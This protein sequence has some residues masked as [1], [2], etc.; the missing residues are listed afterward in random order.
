MKKLSI[1]ILILLAC[2]IFTGCVNSRQKA[3][4]HYG[5][6]QIL[7]AQGKYKEAAAEYKNAANFYPN[8][9]EAHIAYQ[10]LMRREGKNKLLDTEYKTNL[11]L[12][13]QNPYAIFYYGRLAQTSSERVDYYKNALQKDPNFLWAIKSL[14][15]ELIKQGSIDEAI[16]QLK[17]VIE[18]DSEF[19]PVHLSLA[20]AWILKKDY[21]A[22]ESEI[23]KYLQLKPDDYAGLETYGLL[24][25]DKK[26]PEKAIPL[27]EKAIEQN[28]TL[29]S[30]KFH[31][32]QTNY[33]LNR[34]KVA[35]EQIESILKQ[36]PNHTNAL[37]LK[38]KLLVKNKKLPEAFVY[39]Q[40]VLEKQP[41]NM[42]ALHVKGDLFIRSHNFSEAEKTYKS[43]I[44]KRSYDYEALFAMAKIKYKNAEI[45]ESIPY[46]TK[47]AQ[48]NPQDTYSMRILRDWHALAG[49]FKKSEY[50]AEKI[51]SLPDP[52]SE[53]YLKLGLVQWENK[54]L[55]NASGNF[56]KTD[57]DAASNDI[58]ILL[59]T[60]A[61]CKKQHSI[62]LSELINLSS[63]SS[64]SKR[65]KLYKYE[66]EI[67]AGKYN[68]FFDYYEKNKKTGEVEHILAIWSL[69]RQSNKIKAQKLIQTVKKS[70]KFSYTAAN[71]IAILES[72][73]FADKNNADLY[74][75]KLLALENN[76]FYFSMSRW[77]SSE[78]SRLYQLKNDMKNSKI[79]NLNAIRLGKN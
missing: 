61:E 11:E 1:L 78:L 60:T 18:I 64:D 28:P 26:E 53:D 24:L 17:K 74:I 52:A 14:G 71:A 65:K 30:T 44:A 68:S 42:E 3:N 38:A 32:A 15:D 46:F 12:N 29:T 39:I 36:H 47:A 51:C 70:N 59:L 54:F 75:K 50:W 21:N 45:S 67:L 4:E 49:D 76:I 2:P 34:Y 66:A 20:K 25:I 73:A 31:L 48:L 16:K 13:P 6:A 62:I 72:E 33:L 8:F 77:L 10:D 22:A 63:K 19:A 69:L 58:F 56:R 9:T 57:E 41:E 43:I 35:S 7:Y 5:S 37:I 23:K 79:K 55:S 40:R 27:F